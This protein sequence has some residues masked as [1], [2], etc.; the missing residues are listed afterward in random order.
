MTDFEK[1][2]EQQWE[3]FAPNFKNG[4]AH[5]E[6]APDLTLQL[7]PGGGF[8]DLSHPT[9]RLMLKYLKPL[10]PGATV[11]DIGCGSGILSL[12]ASLLGAKAVY[13]VDIEPVAVAHSLKNL[14]INPLCKNVHFAE[15]LSAISFVEPLVIL[16]NMIPAEQEQAWKSQAFLHPRPKRLLTSGILKEFKASYLEWASRQGLTPL[17][18]HE[19]EGW[20]CFEF[21][22]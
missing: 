10:V 19:E 22:S 20:L 13:G 4:R 2:W 1:L 6:I 17:A 5:L 18:C 16:M 12:A 21:I 7:L 15:A 14:S 3:L 8:G 9:T 11:I